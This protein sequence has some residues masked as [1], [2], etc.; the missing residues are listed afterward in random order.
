MF[1][2]C[3]RKLAIILV[4]D[5]VGKFF[6]PS[7]FLGHHLCCPLLH[8]ISRSAL[9]YTYIIVSKNLEGRGAGGRGRAHKFR[10]ALLACSLQFKVILLIDHYKKTPN[11]QILRD[12]KVKTQSVFTLSDC[13]DETLYF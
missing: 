5:F 13:L 1:Q 10:S 8:L 3:F 2:S 11:E 6:S 4:S 9:Y 12:L 7:C